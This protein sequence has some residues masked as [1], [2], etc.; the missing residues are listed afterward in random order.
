MPILHSCGARSRLVSGGRYRSAMSDIER[1]RVVAT[2]AR[3]RSMNMAARAHGIAQSTVTRYVAATERSLGI[4][5]FERGPG[6]AAPAPSAGPAL[7]LIERIVADLAELDAL[8]G[9]PVRSVTISRTAEIGLPDYLEGRIT[10]WNL[11][12]QLQIEQS[13]VD[14]PVAALRSAECDLAVAR[15]EGPMLIG[16]ETRVVRVWARGVRIE[17]L[18]RPDASPQTRAVLDHLT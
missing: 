11:E 6:G 18:N 9:A 16:L 17:L 5:L 12:H 1:F 14:D 8:T 2:L 13:I 4:S 3:T 10:R 15:I 7:A